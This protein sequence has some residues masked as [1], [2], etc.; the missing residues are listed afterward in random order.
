MTFLNRI[1][2]CNFN[3]MVAG[4]KQFYKNLAELVSTDKDKINFFDQNQKAFFLDPESYEWFNMMVQYAKNQNL[5]EEKIV[6]F[7]SFIV[8]PKTWYENIMVNQ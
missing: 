4:E 2:F 5:A 7:V 6:D 1:I 8:Y 3:E